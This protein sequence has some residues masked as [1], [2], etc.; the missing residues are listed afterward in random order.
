MPAPKGHPL[1]GNPLNVKKYTPEELVE[2]FGEYLEWCKNNPWLKVDFI[3]S[4]ENAGNKVYLET[5]R[6]PSIEEF[7]TFLKITYQT[8]LNYSKADGY[9]TYFEAC[10]H[11]RQYI[12]GNHFSGGMAGVYNAN[13]TM[14][15]LGLTE[16]NDITTA[17]MPMQDRKFVMEI[18]DY[19]KKE[20]ENNENIS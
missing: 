12:D 5:E 10:T 4:G 11:I 2:K 14:R 16:K 17:G 20:E 18:Y 15:K 1:W 8:F 9:E 13:I 19:S 3:K 7:C 6:P